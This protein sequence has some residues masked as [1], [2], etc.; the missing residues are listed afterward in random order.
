MTTNSKRKEIVFTRVELEA[1]PER[2]LKELSEHGTDYERM[3]AQNVLVERSMGVTASHGHA[4]PKI[5]PVKTLAK[6]RGEVFQ[7]KQ[8]SRGPYGRRKRD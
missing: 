4:P 8:K 6:P 1:M 5:E 3:H 7:I 2:R